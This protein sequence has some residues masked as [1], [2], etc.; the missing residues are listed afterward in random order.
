MDLLLPIRRSSHIS[1]ENA[2]FPSSQNPIFDLDRSLV[3]EF[4]DSYLIRFSVISKFFHG[5]VHNNV[6]DHNQDGYDIEDANYESSG[7]QPGV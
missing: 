7:T 4:P 6:E 3:C 1:P 2:I 5:G